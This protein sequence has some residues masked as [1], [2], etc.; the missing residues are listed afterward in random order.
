VAGDGKSGYSGDGGDAKLARLSGPKGVAVGPQ[1]D[2][3]LA[4]TE[5][6]TIRVICKAT[7]IIE[8]VIGDGKKG[9]GPDGDPRKC[10][11]NRPHGVF[12]DKSGNLYVGDSENNK[13]RKLTW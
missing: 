10:Q 11:L 3:Y 5:S 4:D 6:N 12:F 2:I 1:G 8:T 13:V 7:G 9:D